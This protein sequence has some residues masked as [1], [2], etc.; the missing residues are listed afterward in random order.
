VV[1]IATLFSQAVNENII[2]PHAQIEVALT[3]ITLCF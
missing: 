3:F 1:S 2:K